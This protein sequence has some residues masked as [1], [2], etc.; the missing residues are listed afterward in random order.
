MA[1]PRI[2][3]MNIPVLETAR[4]RL[5][6]H[7]A[8]D[9]AA[10]AAMWADL[11]VVAHITGRASTN[12]ESWMRLLRAPGLW[13]ILGYGYW[14]V[15]ERDSGLFVGDVGFG[16]FRREMEPSIAGLPEIGWVLSPAIY[17][18]GYATEAVSAALAWADAHLDAAETVCIIDPDNTASLRV[19]EKTGFGAPEAAR[20]KDADILLFSRP[21]RT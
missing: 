7:R 14:A 20:Y 3:R 12:E 19:A 2:D 10:C 4:L 6:A 11:R 8:E 15:E 5:R 21:R 9:F 16:D 17:G 13:A 18:K 1:E